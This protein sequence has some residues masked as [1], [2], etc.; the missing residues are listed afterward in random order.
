MTDV[1]GLGT[2]CAVAQSLVH[3]AISHC[4]RT[5]E[6][7]TT[8]NH[9]LRSPLHEPQRGLTADSFNTR[10]QVPQR[11]AGSHLNRPPAFSCPPCANSQ[12]NSFRLQ[13]LWRSARPSIKHAT[14][15]LQPIAWSC[16]L[17][18]QRSFTRTIP[19][20]L[21][22]FSVAVTDV[23]RTLLLSAVRFGNRK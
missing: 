23:L 9:D 16:R 22:S 7:R 17:S 10:V 11:P 4:I 3:R 12:R 18:R 2:G 1:T 5:F 8:L 6:D 13:E 15:A 21:H 19:A 14:F 20:L